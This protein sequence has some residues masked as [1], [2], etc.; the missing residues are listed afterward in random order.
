MQAVTLAA[1]AAGMVAIPLFLFLGFSKKA[2][3]RSERRVS[4]QRR[5]EDTAIRLSGGSKDGDSRSRRS[6]RHRHK[7]HEA[8]IDLFQRQATQSEKSGAGPAPADGPQQ[9]DR[10]QDDG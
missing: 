7:S 3:R 6:R 9:A 2:A 1:A 4:E 10:Q 5:S 8:P